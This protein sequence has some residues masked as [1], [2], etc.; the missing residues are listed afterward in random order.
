MRK[1]AL[2]YLFVFLLF[3]LA[4]C[5]GGGESVGLSEKEENASSMPGETASSR[6]D[7]QQD[8]ESEE[9]KDPEH[10][11]IEGDAFSTV[12]RFIVSGYGAGDMSDEEIFFQGKV[13]RKLIGYGARQL[14]M[15]RES[16]FLFYP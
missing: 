2:F 13:H 12:Y 16:L 4:G 9:Q 3:F 14:G 6:S 7:D 8:S 1:T 11:Q 10:L 15:G 5:A